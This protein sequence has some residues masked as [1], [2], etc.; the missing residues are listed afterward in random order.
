[1][2]SI[3]GEERIGRE[4]GGYGEYLRPTWAGAVLAE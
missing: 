3:C 1:M 4:V 2:D